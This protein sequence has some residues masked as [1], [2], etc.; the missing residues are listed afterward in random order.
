[1]RD[2]IY[3]TYTPT[4]APGAYHAAI[5]YERADQAG[6]AIKHF[7]IE[8][9][10]ENGEMLSAPAKAIGVFEEAFREGDGPSRFGSIEA[11]VRDHEVSAHPK[12]RSDDANA[13]YEIIAEGDDLGG[14][15]ARIE[16]LKSFDTSGKSLA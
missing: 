1:M 5:H 4:D 3:V 14:H 8:A 6:N 7:V 9:K 12:E 10:P 11:K 2:R 16:F 15:L 13:P